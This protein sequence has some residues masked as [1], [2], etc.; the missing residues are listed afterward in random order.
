MVRVKMLWHRDKRPWK[1]FLCFEEYDDEADWMYVKMDVELAIRWRHL[2]YQ[3]RFD[4]K[5]WQRTKKATMW[6]K[7]RKRIWKIHLGKDGVEMD[8]KVL[9][10]CLEYTK[11]K[12]WF[13]WWFVK[14]VWAASGVADKKLESMG[15]TREV[16][17][18]RG[19]VLLWKRC[20]R[21]Y[22]WYRFIGEPHC[23][24]SSSSQYNKSKTRK[25]KCVHK[26]MCNVCGVE[27]EKDYAQRGHVL[28]ALREAV[29]E[30]VEAE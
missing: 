7:R 15:Y 10:K 27:V 23:G 19:V 18:G 6:I 1:R 16:K 4:W 8:H 20:G 22:Y 21:C 9:G 26:V 29:Q 12:E 11:R 30:F 13:P 25:D 28:C 14:K 5:F 24:N 17:E 3:Y 2:A